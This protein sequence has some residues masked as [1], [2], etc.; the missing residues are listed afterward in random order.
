VKAGVDVELPGYSCFK[1]GLERAQARGLLDIAEIDQA[2]TR[3]LVEKSRLG[4]FEHPYTDEQAIKLNTKH[5]RELAAEAAAKSMVL[6][7]NNGI[8]PLAKQGSTALVGPLAEDGLCMCGAYSFPLHI[9]SSGLSQEKAGSGMKTLRQC[10][11]RRLGA[12]LLYARGCDILE[13]RPKEAPVFPGEVGPEDRSGAPRLSD[14]ESGISV[15]VETA[16]KADRVIL[17]VGD[18]AGMFRTGTVG[19]GSDVSSLRL[20]GVQQKLLEALLGTGKPVVVVL[21]SGRPYYLGEAFRGASAVLEA[22]L[23]GQ[24]GAEAIAGVLLGE[25]NPGA[26]PFFYNHNPKSGGMPLQP[27]F[28]AEYPFGFGLSY[29][30]F[31]FDEFAVAEPFAPMDGQFELSFRLT[32]TGDREGEEVAQLYVRDLYASQVRPVMELKGFRRIALPPKGSARVSFTV[33]A[34]MLGFTGPDNRRI[35]EPGQF[36]LMIGSSSRDI[37]FRQVVT[38][39]GETKTLPEN[40]RMQSAV[41]VRRI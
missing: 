40:W 12:G 27:D 41:R 5:G 38:L 11:E 31:S 2:V 33:P 15:A 35:L 14:D 1:E 3:I 10:L 32:N 39:Q 4:L 26:L 34:D 9:L 37:H 22:W 20:P 8:L 21:I 23:P 13:E 24:E 7:K 6:L 28:G 25:T 29:T 16:G 17:A 19:E 30:S 18:Q 36:E